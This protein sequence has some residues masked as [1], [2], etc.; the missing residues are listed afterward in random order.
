M[1]QPPQISVYKVGAYRSRSFAEAGNDRYRYTVGYAVTP[2]GIVGVYTQT[3]LTCLI[4]A[5]DGHEARAQWERTFSD[6]GLIRICRQFAA[7]AAAAIAEAI[8]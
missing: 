8:R 7:E 4:F 3:R 5:Q 6:R 1:T 2:D